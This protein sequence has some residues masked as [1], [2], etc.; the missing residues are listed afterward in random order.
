MKWRKESCRNAVER[1]CQEEYYLERNDNKKV[2]TC[3]DT[4]T[5]FIDSSQE[6]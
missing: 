2:F 3:D 4:E 6:S 1:T 5:G